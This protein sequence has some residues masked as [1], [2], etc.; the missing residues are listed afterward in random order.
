MII[1]KLRE[2]FQ[3][4]NSAVKL[5]LSFGF[6]LHDRIESGEYRYYY[7]ADNNP[8]FPTPITLENES[9]LLTLQSRLEQENFLHDCVM[10]RPNTKWKFALLQT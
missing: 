3:N 5:N 2:V 8:V 7:A 10:H 1:E 4:L 9:D 6:V